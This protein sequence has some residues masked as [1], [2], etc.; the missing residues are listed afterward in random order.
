MV[1]HLLSARGA[2]DEGKV[3]VRTLTLPDTYQDHDTP[4]RMYAQAG[5]DAASI[6]KVVEA[7]LPARS[8]NLS[9]GNVVSVARRQR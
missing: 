3:R 9:A 2:L 8:E 6:V 5:L 4:E 7:T 1:L